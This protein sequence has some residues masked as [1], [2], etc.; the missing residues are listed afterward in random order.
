MLPCGAILSVGHFG[1]CISA[2]NLIFESLLHVF[3]V[4]TFLALSEYMCAHAKVKFA[5][6]IVVGVTIIQ[7]KQFDAIDVTFE[8]HKPNIY[9]RLVNLHA[10]QCDIKLAI[11][12]NSNPFR[13]AQRPVCLPP[14]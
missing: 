14:I 8:L 11:H 4:F 2:P 13:L 10:C 12:E 3:N 5:R 1:F 7:N 9:H 6:E